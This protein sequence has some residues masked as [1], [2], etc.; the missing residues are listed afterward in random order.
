MDACISKALTNTSFTHTPT[1]DDK[2]FPSACS[3]FD[4]YTDTHRTYAS[5][6]PR[7]LKASS[8]WQANQEVDPAETAAIIANIEERVREIYNL[9]GH[10]EDEGK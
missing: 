1:S 9:E 7:H 10:K 2:V 6:V 5:L 3:F 4:S 8:H